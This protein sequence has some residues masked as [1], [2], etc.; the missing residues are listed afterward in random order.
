MGPISFAGSEKFTPK[1]FQT[2]AKLQLIFVMKKKARP[3]AQ[4][5]EEA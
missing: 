2:E 5:R 1:F 3:E 4:G